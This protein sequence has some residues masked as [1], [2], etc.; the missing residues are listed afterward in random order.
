MDGD[1]D[2]QSYIDENCTALLSCPGD[3]HFLLTSGDI[4]LSSAILWLPVEKASC[5]WHGWRMA[6][7]SF[8][9]HTAK[10]SRPASKI[11]DGVDEE[12]R[13]SKTACKQARGSKTASA[14][15]DGVQ[16]SKTPHNYRQRC[17]SKLHRPPPAAHASADELVNCMPKAD[18][19]VRKT[20]YTRCDQNGRT[21]LVQVEEGVVNQELEAELNRHTSAARGSRSKTNEAWSDVH[22]VLHAHQIYI[23]PFSPVMRLW[24]VLSLVASCYHLIVVPI[25]LSF[26]GVLQQSWPWRVADVVCS[27]LLLADLVIRAF[28]AY[29]D[30]DTS[31]EAD[32]QTVNTLSTNRGSMP[33]P[34]AYVRGLLLIPRPVW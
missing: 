9:V 17:M 29:E 11:L 24:E 6:P 25:R 16:R 21:F 12:A 4:R 19:K 23:H 22:H 32:Q 28:V 33:H 1:Q 18:A 27:V 34:H 2:F 3:I 26:P 20:W 31:A 30:N 5:A 15:L 7:H 13:G 14:T 8:P 10:S